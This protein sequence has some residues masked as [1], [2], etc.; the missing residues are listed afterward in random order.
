MC[1]RARGG[2][3]LAADARFLSRVAR[4]Q[5]PDRQEDP[6]EF[7]L[8]IA[9]LRVCLSSAAA[10]L[11]RAALQREARLCHRQSKTTSVSLK[12]LV[13]CFKGGQVEAVQYLQQVRAVCEYGGN[14]W[15][16]VYL[17]RA[18]HRCSG[19]DAILTL[20]DDVAWRWIFPAE[21]LRLQ[22]KTPAG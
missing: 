9:R 15:L 4:K 21:L 16:R 1:S 17:L 2:G 6:A 12:L 13:V 5:S 14:D 8:T 3:E 22:V 19:M 18:L 20:M 10:L 11:G 7:L